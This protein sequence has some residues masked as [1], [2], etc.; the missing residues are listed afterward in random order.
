MKIYNAFGIKP[1]NSYV[2][3]GS[4]YYIPNLDTEEKVKRA[5]LAFEKSYNRTS[6]EIATI[7]S[8]FRNNVPANILPHVANLVHLYLALYNKD[9]KWFE[10]ESLEKA[11]TAFY[12]AYVV[13]DAQHDKVGVEMR[14]N[15]TLFINSGLKVALDTVLTDQVGPNPTDTIQ[16][17]RML[18]IGMAGLYVNKSGKGNAGWDVRA[19]LV[20]EDY[21][22][23][24]HLSMAYT[25]DVIDHKQN[26]VYCG[27]KFTQMMLIPVFHTEY[28]EV[29][30]DTYNHV[31]KDSKRGDNGFD[32]TGVKHDSIDTTTEE[33]NNSIDTTTEDFNNSNELYN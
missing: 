26:I 16:K 11:V 14:V 6:E 32:S 3:A 19:Q 20:D 31:M 13:Y 17:L 8:I 28:E 22:G 27:D 15:D 23:F 4:D 9:I 5:Y 30:E 18:G 25:K 33:F 12:E 29:D 1:T 7:D 10:E 24:V 21:T 2:S